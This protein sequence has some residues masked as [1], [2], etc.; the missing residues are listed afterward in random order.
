MLIGRITS[1][2][3]KVGQR[4]TAVDM[5]GKEVESAKVFKLIRRFGTGQIEIS[6]AGA[7]DIVLVAG[8]TKATVTHTINEEGKSEVIPVSKYKLYI[9][10]F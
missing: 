9:I 3:I 1:G 10:I 5:D 7:G 8:F 6:E 2:T 4:V